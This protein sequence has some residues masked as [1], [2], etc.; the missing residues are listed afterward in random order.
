MSYCTVDRYGGFTNTYAHAR[1]GGEN[2]RSTGRTW[3]P[4][5]GPST[6]DFSAQPRS[7]PSEAIFDSVIA[8]GKWST[9]ERVAP[10]AETLA[11]K[12]RNPQPARAAML[13]P[14]PSA[15]EMLSAHAATERQSALRRMELR[16]RRVDSWL[17][18]SPISKKS[19][20]LAEKRTRSEPSL[21][22]SSSQASQVSREVYQRHGFLVGRSKGSIADGVNGAQ[23]RRHNP[24]SLS[25][26]MFSGD[27]MG[28][29]GRKTRRAF[30]SRKPTQQWRMSPESRYVF[31]PQICLPVPR[32]GWNSLP[33]SKWPDVEPAGN[34]DTA[35]GIDSF[36]KASLPAAANGT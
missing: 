23:P 5:F 24:L 4:D 27:M 12:F 11:P 20:P 16:Q 36:A 33:P 18:Q 6:R 9:R 32:G 19:S 2:S 1:G 17:E 34:R 22:L 15:E 13:S 7:H 31:D 14:S 8:P 25:S 10:S 3:W 35:P 21:E 28:S 30:R 29:P 26:M